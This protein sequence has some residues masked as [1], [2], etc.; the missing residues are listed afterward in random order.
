MP[1][2]NTPM[3]DD[4]TFVDFLVRPYYAIIGDVFWVL[5]LMIVVGM[6]WMKTRQMGP[7]LG[8]AIMG[9]AI[10]SQVMYNPLMQAT[11]MFFVAIGVGIV[12]FRVAVSGLG[13]R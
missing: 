3:I 2:E 5:V 7:T 4:N 6:V 12:L 8:V 11:F 10:F 1:F 9:S 13:R